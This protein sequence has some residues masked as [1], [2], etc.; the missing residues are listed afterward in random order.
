MLNIQQKNHL[1]LLLDV[2][3]L[4]PNGGGDVRRHHLVL[5]LLFGQLLLERL[6]LRRLLLGRLLDC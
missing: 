5:W 3:A 4:V 2:H 1:I 6:L